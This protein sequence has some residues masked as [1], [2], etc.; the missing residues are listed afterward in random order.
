MSL[1]SADQQTN[2]SISIENL[3][4]LETT[5]TLMTSPASGHTLDTFYT[6]V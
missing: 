3:K 1:G 6:N 2:G 5:L 4:L